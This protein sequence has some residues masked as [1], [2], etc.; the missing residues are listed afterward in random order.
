MRP[1]V[2]YFCLL[3]KNLIVGT[4]SR[5]LTDYSDS[6]DKMIGM[7]GY[8]IINYLNYTRQTD[9]MDG[10]L[11]LLAEKYPYWVLLPQLFPINFLEDTPYYISD[12]LLRRV[13]V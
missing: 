12:F 7:R 8:K 2:Y 1:F 9:L 3:E 11:M 4:S 5:C 10:E 13:C 6:L